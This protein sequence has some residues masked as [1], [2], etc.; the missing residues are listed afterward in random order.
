MILLWTVFLLFRHFYSNVDK[1]SIFVSFF[2]AHQIVHLYCV[3]KTSKYPNQP[4]WVA[5]HRVKKNVPN[6]GNTIESWRQHEKWRDDMTTMKRVQRYRVNCNFANAELSANFVH[7][8]LYSREWIKQ[9][10]LLYVTSFRACFV[11]IRVYVWV[12][13]RV[14]FF[15][16]TD[17]HLHVLPAV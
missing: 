15:C 1:E 10:F 3:K 14:I 4:Y 6:V 16:I 17:S 12:W 2:F 5:F 11:N 8:T 7:N 13:V 9:V